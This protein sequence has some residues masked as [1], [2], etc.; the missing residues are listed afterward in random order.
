[1]LNAAG[2]TCYVEHNAG[3]GAGFSDQEYENAGARIVY[4]GHEVF[5]RADLLL[6]VS[7]PL[8][9]ELEWVRPWTTHRWFAAPGVQPSRQGENFK[10]KNHSNIHESIQT[11]DGD[12]L[13]DD[14]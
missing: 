14:H 11:A 6:K 8:Y 10:R 7:R 5:G 3:I 2:H 13:C 9:E 12:R 1:M 4:S